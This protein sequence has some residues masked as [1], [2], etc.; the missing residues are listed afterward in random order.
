MRCSPVVLHRPTDFSSRHVE[1]PLGN[2]G[3][4]GDG[5]AVALFYFVVGEGPANRGEVL[6]PFLHIAIDARA[7]DSRLDLR[8]GADDPRVVQEA[9]DVL[10]AELGDLRR[11]E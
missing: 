4:R 6:T 3:P 2:V 10:L 1:D 9:K 7:A 8:A 5:L 11:L